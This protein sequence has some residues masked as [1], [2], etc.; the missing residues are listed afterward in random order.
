MKIPKQPRAF[1]LGMFYFSAE[2]RVG[3]LRQHDGVVDLSYPLLSVGRGRVPVGALRRKEDVEDFVKKM[4]HDAALLAPF[5]RCG[6]ILYTPQQ[7]G[8]FQR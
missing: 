6:F 7:E 1:C 4:P 8:V 5:S 3:A 2:H